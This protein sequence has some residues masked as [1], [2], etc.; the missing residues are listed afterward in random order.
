MEAAV[1][2]ILQILTD[3]VRRL[4]GAGALNNA[5]H[6]VRRV[7]TSAGELDRQLARLELMPP[8]AA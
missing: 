8:R 2:T 4:A 7:T 1:P 5:A 6:E 3:A